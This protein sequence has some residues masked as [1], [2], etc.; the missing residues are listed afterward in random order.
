MAD[1][2][3]WPKPKYNPGPQKHLHAIGVISTCYNAFEESMF[4]LYRH[5]PDCLKL[6]KC[7]SEEFLNHMNQ[8]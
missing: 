6:P 1:E 2:D 8:L 3:L 5:H 4:E 7:L